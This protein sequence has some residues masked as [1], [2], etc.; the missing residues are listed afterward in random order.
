MN[1]E[2]KI[3]TTD[4][5]DYFAFIS[6]NSNDEAEAK[7]LHRTLGRWRLPASLV[8]E[9]GLASKPMQKLFFAPSDIV[10]K[11]L[12]EVLKENLRAS[13]HLIVVCSPTSAKSAWVGFEI[14]YFCSLGRKENVH[15]IIVDGEPKS[16]N[17]DTECFHPNLK[18]H[19]NDLLS[20]NIHERHFKL[21]YLN[22][23]RAYVQLI[24]A[25]LDVKFD[26]I[27]R[28]HRRRMMEKAFF[29]F[30]LLSA[31]VIS[32]FAVW[33][34]NRHGSIRLNLTEQTPHNPHLPPLRN[35]QVS[36]TINQKTYTATIN[37]F[38]DTV[39]FSDIP[40]S[41]FDDSARLKIECED[42]FAI[43]TTLIPSEQ[44]TFGLSR[45]ASVYGRYKGGLASKTTGEF[46]ANY[47]FSVE[48]IECVTDENGMFEIFVPLERQK[49]TMLLKCDLNPQGFGVSFGR[50]DGLWFEPD[51]KD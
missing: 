51:A 41:S 33:Q 48:G 28:R 11:E 6:Y 18:K 17:P 16:Q 10:P 40:Y 23:Q 32:L 50:E 19:F 30:C 22:R 42:W 35:A 21:P 34:T 39:T 31:F 26:A 4:G 27:W 12:E 24:A 8:K 1:K 47:P 7:K 20:A 43:D 14:D 13:E 49:D 46:L 44:M 36:L 29:W 2:K 38:E 3:E 25:M 9:K 15:L 5:Y 37:S 45:D